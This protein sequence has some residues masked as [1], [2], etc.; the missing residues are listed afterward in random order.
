MLLNPKGDSA[1]TFK[2][3]WVRFSYAAPTGDGMNIYLLCDP[4]NE[5]RRSS[6]YTTFW[7]IGLG[8]D[9]NYLALDVVRDRL[10]LT[11]RTAKLFDLHRHWKPLRVGYEKYGMQA[12]IEHIK[13]EQDRRNYRFDVVELGGQTP[14][15][16][17]IK[18]LIPLFEGGRFYLQHSRMYTDYEGRTANLID[19]FIEEEYKAFPV[20]AHDDM[21]DC[22][23][24]I[25]DPELR[26]EFPR[27]GRRAAAMPKTVTG[28][29]FADM[30]R[31]Y[32]G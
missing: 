16:D 4:A 21:L 22:M 19:V 9:Q 8:P 31:R 27:E 23:A 29:R 7:V 3:E 1:Q 13:T 11:E 18:K 6:D 26:A 5:K 14:K 15:L 32:N 30:R 20:M 10:N 17:R 2:S 24:R 25:V 28:S 12:D